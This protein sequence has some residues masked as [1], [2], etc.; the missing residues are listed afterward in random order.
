MSRRKIR[1]TRDDYAALARGLLKQL[2]KGQICF[3]DSMELWH[4]FPGNTLRIDSAGWTKIADTIAVKDCDGK[5]LQIESS[6]LEIARLRIANIHLQEK[7]IRRDALLAANTRHA[8]EVRKDVTV[9]M[10]NNF[11]QKLEAFGHF[12]H[13]LKTPFSLLISIAESLAIHG[14]KIPAKIRV[15]LEYIR[16]G[17]HRVLR[18]AG[19][20]I[21]AAQLFSRRTRTNRVRADLSKFVGE[22]AMMYALVFENYGISLVIKVKP[23]IFAE[24]DPLQFEKVLNNLLSNAIK[25]NIAG[26]RTVIALT[27]SQ[28]KASLTIS[29]NGLGFASGKDS[30]RRVRDENPWIFSSHG[31]GLK[32]V[33]QYI[34]QNRGEFRIAESPKG[35]A[36]TITL[37]ISNQAAANMRHA[38]Q[39]THREIEFLA[40][41]RTKLS[42]RRN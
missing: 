31:Y 23:G 3:E 17:I 8:N 11:E 16:M 28:G 9:R 20:S 41:E 38:M 42:R 36:V 18:E 14:E 15:K 25:H 22:V 33:K 27:S 39:F 7:L 37:P 40:A 30:P 4:V 35:V 2:P 21:D 26:G 1:S 6:Q 19:N 13:D 5:S 34:R 12:S 29:D 32:I 24:F 10:Q